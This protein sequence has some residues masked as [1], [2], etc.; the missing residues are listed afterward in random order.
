MMGQAQSLVMKFVQSDEYLIVKFE[1]MLSKTNEILT[2]YVQKKNNLVYACMS[3]F[4]IIWFG[5]V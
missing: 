2:K 5:F 4:N 1:V 3:F